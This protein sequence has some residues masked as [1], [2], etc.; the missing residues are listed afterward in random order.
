VC[1]SVS[2]AFATLGFFLHDWHSGPIHLYI[3][4]RDRLAP[5]DGQV[6]LNGFADFPLLTCS[7]VGANGLRRALDRFGR[8]F[9]TSQHFHLLASVIKGNFLSHHGL[10]PTHTG[11]EVRLLYVQRLVSGRLPFMAMRTQIPGTR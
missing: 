10:H 1:R 7:D 4:D 5:D 2:L 11:R 3:E 6:Q 9:Q 8:H